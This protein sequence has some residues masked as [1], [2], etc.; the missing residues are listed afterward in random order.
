MVGVGPP[1]MSFEELLKEGLRA[2]RRMVDAGFRWLTEAGQRQFV[3]K[4][5]VLDSTLNS[6][7]VATCMGRF[8]AAELDFEAPGV[9]GLGRISEVIPRYGAYFRKHMTSMSPADIH[10]LRRLMMGQL[11]AGY[12][13]HVVI[14]E[15]EVR[16]PA[17]RRSEE[18]FQA[19]IPLIYS[20]ALPR[21]IAPDVMQVLLVLSAPSLEEHQRFLTERRMRGPGLLSRNRTGEI[22]HH[23]P[24]AGFA[25]RSVETRGK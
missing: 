7:A 25:L 13:S 24:L 17:L 20:S 5:A 23:Y 2:F 6:A 11:V 4:L 12:A 19:W 14:V 15:D 10:L 9:R 22:L 1:T 8:V 16:S 21:S 18:I 3:E